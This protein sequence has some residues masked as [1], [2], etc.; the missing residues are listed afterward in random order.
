MWHTFEVNISKQLFSIKKWGEEIQIKISLFYLHIL[1]I[2]TPNCK[3]LVKNCSLFA[4]TL[5]N[6][7]IL[8]QKKL[9]EEVW[10]KNVINSFVCN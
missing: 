8:Q 3:K 5:F 6:F 10:N 1:L 4:F 9:Q 2:L 7:K